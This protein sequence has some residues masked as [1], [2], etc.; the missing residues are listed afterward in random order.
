L[1]CCD[2][3]ALRVDYDVGV[4]MSGESNEALQVVLSVGREGFQQ[5]IKIPHTSNV[6]KAN[7][8]FPSELK[9]LQFNDLFCARVC[10]VRL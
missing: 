6:A 8:L 7:I 3:C 5:F 4:G 10:F 2:I 9:L 1:I